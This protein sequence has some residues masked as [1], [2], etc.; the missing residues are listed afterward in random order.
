MMDQ[1]VGSRVDR[2]LEGIL[3]P[4]QLEEYK[5]AFRKTTAGAGMLSKIKNG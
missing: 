3:R 5:E 1:C 2:Y 4:K